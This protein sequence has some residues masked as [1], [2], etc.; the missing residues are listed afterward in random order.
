MTG[1]VENLLRSGRH[2]VALAWCHSCNMNLLW[3]ILS[4]NYA[5]PNRSKTRS[6][7]WNYK[8]FYSA[9]PSVDASYLLSS[10]LFSWLRR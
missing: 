7:M 4:D 10:I 8:L 1:S 9:E 6:S 3:L 5:P 2:R